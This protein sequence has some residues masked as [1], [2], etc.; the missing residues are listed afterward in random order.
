MATKKYTFMRVD[1]EAYEALKKRIDEINRIDLK[2]VKT[3]LTQ[4]DMTRYLF[5]NRVWISNNELINMM[6]NRNRGRQC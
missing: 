3:K 5:K 6:K 2:K 1:R 4:M